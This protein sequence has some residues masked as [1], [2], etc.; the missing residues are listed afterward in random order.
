[1]AYNKQINKDKK[2][3]TVFVPQHFSQQ[4]FAHY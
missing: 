1:M 4:N 3:L 2:Q